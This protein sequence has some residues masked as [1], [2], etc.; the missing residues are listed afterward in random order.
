MNPLT[1]AKWIG[2]A[3]VVK[4]VFQLLSLLAFTRLLEPH[5]FGLVAIAVGVAN[6]ANVLRDM[7]TGAAIIQQKTLDESLKGA[8]FVFNLALGFVL[9]ALLAMLGGPVAVFMNSPEVAGL[10]FAIA[11]TFPIGS[12]AVVHQALLER[13]SAFAT[14]A[15]I[16]VTAAAIGFAV[17][18]IAALNRFGAYSLVLQTASSTI[19]AAIMLWRG[20]GWRPSWS[21]GLS[22]FRGLAKFST[23]VAAFNLV[24]YVSRN[25]DAFIIGR[26]LGPALLGAYSVAYRLMLFPVQALTFVSARALY[27]VMSGRHAK[28]QDITPLYF[29]SLRL[30]TLLAAPVLG[31]MWILREE[32]SSVVFGGKW[33]EVAIL[34]A[35]MA[36]TGYVQCIVS[37]AGAVY[38][39]LGQ[40]ALMLRLGF[41]GA[42]LTL[43]AFV[44]GAMHGLV[45]IAMFYFVANVVNFFVV[46]ITT[47]KL[48]NASWRTY[49]SATLVPL[50]AAAPIL[51]S[52]HTALAITQL[53][54]SSP[55]RLLLGVFSALIAAAVTWILTGRSLLLWVSGS[56]AVVSQNSREEKNI[57]PDVTAIVVIM[58]EEEKP[59][60]HSAVESAID[61]GQNTTVRVY[62]NEALSWMPDIER[63]FGK[64]GQLVF[65]GM[66]LAHAARVRNLGVREATTNWVGFLDGDDE[67]TRGKTITQMEVAASGD[68]DFVGGDHIMVDVR[69]RPFC[70][71]YPRNI[72]MLSTWLVRRDEMIA[73]PF[74]EELFR[75]EDAHWWVTAGRHLRTVRVPAICCLY[76]VRINS[77]SSINKTKKRKETIHSLAFKYRMRWALLLASYLVWM[78]TRRNGYRGHSTWTSDK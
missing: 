41:I 11:I 30:I 69:K 51:L 37:S 26:V 46:A 3:Q 36:P 32:V 72:P 5:D 8:A 7:G 73:H 65:I 67:W 78:A 6:F 56:N 17:G 47:R 28:G 68:F 25:A 44:A 63:G 66:P 50:A 52:T 60:A 62:Y 42:S 29:R 22:G 38:M 53:E 13:E 43:L 4:N 45:T 33:S 16:E 20:S 35:W 18:V 75:H 70:Y 71:G 14:I 49:L 76:T 58:T 64:S 12:S 19:T 9:A 21:A 57:K 23:H 59:F 77:K 10:L 61:Q 2:L 15:R 1:N 27:P 55:T 39:S 40:T 24:N 48:L 74:N 34:I 31:E 54:I